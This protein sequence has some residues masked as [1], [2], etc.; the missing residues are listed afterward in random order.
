MTEPAS[1]TAHI[2]P[3]RHDFAADP[4]RPLYHFLPPANYMSDPHGILFWKGRHHLFY[5][6][7][8]DGAYDHSARM[9][10]A[11]AA[12]AD[13]VHWTDLPIAIAPTPG[14][15]DAGG[16]FS[17]DSFLDVEGTP[18]IILYGAHR[19]QCLFTSRE[20]MLVNW[21]RHPRNPVIPQEKE[22][23]PYRIYDPCAWIDRGTYYA[24]SG[25]YTPQKRDVAYLFQSKDLAHWE[26][27]HPLYDPTPFTDVGEDCAVPNF[28][29]MGDRHVLLF[30]SHPRGAQYYIGTYEDRKFRPQR[31]GRMNFGGVGLTEGNLFAPTSYADDRGRR[32]FFAWVPEGRTL[33]V[34]KASGWSGI[35]CLPRVLTLSDD[36]TLLTEPAPDLEVLRHNHQHFADIRVTANSPGALEDVFGNC[37]EMALK[38]DPADAHVFEISVCCSPEADEQTVITYSRDDSYLALNVKESS[39]SPDFVGREEQRTPLQLAAGE[40]LKLRLFLDR[41]IVEVFANS[42]LCLTKRIYPSRPDSVGVRL[43][44]RGGTA[45]VQS[46][47]VWQMTPV[48]PTI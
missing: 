6:L 42:R 13:L 47:D 48:W 23:D 4:Y 43:S 25:S 36:D 14:E 33:E 7:N 5:Q 46:M 21:K 15:A 31:H 30:A 10:W 12:S 19:G 17:G 27:V 11:H 45:T 9:H 8:P 37:L 32:I 16:C 18:T 2:D 35:L 44:A 39:M 22:G 34:Q 26:Y 28:F 3:R 1:L 29:T 24:L 40:A 38:I 41:S 20:D